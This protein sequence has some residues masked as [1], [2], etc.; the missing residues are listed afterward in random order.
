[1]SGRPTHRCFK[2]RDV[3]NAGQKRDTACHRLSVCLFLSV[4]PS[5]SCY[6]NVAELTVDG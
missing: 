2:L 3:Q 5:V 6:A 4:R 1:M